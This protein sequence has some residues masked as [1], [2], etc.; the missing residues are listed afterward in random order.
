VRLHSLL[1]P[2]C[3]TELPKI[4]FCEVWKLADALRKHHC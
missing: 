3:I 2:I 4:D 1:K